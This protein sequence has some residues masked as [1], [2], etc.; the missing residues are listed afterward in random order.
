MAYEKPLHGEEEPQ[1]VT[2][3]GLGTQAEG[4]KEIP[5]E[6]ANAIQIEL[7][8]RMTPPKIQPYLTG[9]EDDPVL[10]ELMM[11]F[12]DK[13]YIGFNGFTE[14][15]N[16]NSADRSFI[17]RAKGAKLTD[18]DYEKMATFIQQPPHGKLFF[19]NS[20]EIEAFLETLP[21]PTVH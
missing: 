6:A 19:K 3:I 18:E 17:E 4:R 20:A 11:R 1:Y 15:C 21:K 5:M 14:Y 12:M 7:V 2:P 13:Y 16:L 9:K 8:R 10:G